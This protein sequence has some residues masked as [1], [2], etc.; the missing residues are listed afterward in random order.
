MP[1]L[2]S[3]FV[4]ATLQLIQPHSLLLQE[5]INLHQKKIVRLNNNVTSHCLAM[6]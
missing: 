3:F 2:P 4:K 1:T 5:D 6:V